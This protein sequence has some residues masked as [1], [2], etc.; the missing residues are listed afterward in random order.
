[1]FLDFISDNIVIFVL[2]V[3]LLCFF[4]GF[5]LEWFMCRNSQVYSY[6]TEPIVIAIVMICVF[7]FLEEI[8][9]AKS[10]AVLFIPGW[11]AEVFALAMFGI[12]T[13]AGLKYAVKRKDKK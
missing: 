11:P 6:H 9:S 5:I 7:V 1:M 8:H 12:G 2:M 10:G 4:A 13:T 3:T